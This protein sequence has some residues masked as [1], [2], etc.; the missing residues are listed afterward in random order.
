MLYATAP[1]RALGLL[2]PADCLHARP[3]HGGQ[4]LRLH[5][6]GSQ[7]RFA[8]HP[9]CGRRPPRRDAR[10]RSGLS[11]E[12]RCARARSVAPDAAEVQRHTPALRTTV[13]RVTAGCFHAWSMAGASAFVF[14]SLARNGLCRPLA[15][16]APSGCQGGG[17]GSGQLAL[18]LA[19]L[20][21]VSVEVDLIEV[22][23]LFHRQGAS[24]GV[25]EHC[26]GWAAGCERV[27]VGLQPGV[28]LVPEM[29]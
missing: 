10:A 3:M 23:G 19:D 18:Q 2:A 6:R 27:H 29:A 22:Q 9:V 8:G 17:W 14:T 28:V 24:R 5:Q 20:P 12:P 4:R 13:R 7:Q 16:L 25:L 11:E 21:C 15:P 1:N 26:R